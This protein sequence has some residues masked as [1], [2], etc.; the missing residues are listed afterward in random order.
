MGT[1]CGN[2]IGCSAANAPGRSRTS[3]WRAEDKKNGRSQR[4]SFGQM[5]EVARIELASGSPLQSGLHA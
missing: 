4:P 5:V 1:V 2:F 3:L